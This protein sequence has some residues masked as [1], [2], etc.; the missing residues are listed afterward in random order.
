MR[1]KSSFPVLLILVCA[2]VA[3]SL[4]TRPAQAEP[5]SGREAA[6]GAAHDGIPAVDR[7]EPAKL[8]AMIRSGHAPVILQVGFTMLYTEAHI[9]GA[10]HA[11]PMVSA[12]GRALLEKT[13]ANTDRHAPLVT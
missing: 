4:V 11:G 9:Q 10:I 12:K 5:R 6:S 7:V 8:A 3:V 1:R 2:V 13:T